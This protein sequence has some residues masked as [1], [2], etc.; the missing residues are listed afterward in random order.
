MLIQ[1]RNKNSRGLLTIIALC[2]ISKITGQAILTPSVDPLLYYKAT[3]EQCLRDEECASKCCYSKLCMETLKECASQR[4]ELLSK[5]LSQMEQR[6]LALLSLTQTDTPSILST[7]QEQIAYVNGT[8][9]LFDSSIVQNLIHEYSQLSSISGNT[10]ENQNILDIQELIQLDSKILL[11]SISRREMNSE[12]LLEHSVLQN[13]IQSEGSR[14]G[15]Y[16]NSQGNQIR[17]QQ[18]HNDEEVQKQP[19]QAPVQ[20]IVDSQTNM[21]KPDDETQING[22]TPS[23]VQSSELKNS[24]KDNENTHQETEA[25]LKESQNVQSPVVEESSS[26]TIESNREPYLTAL[27]ILLLLVLLGAGGL[28]VLALKGDSFQMR[29]KEKHW[30]YEQT[31]IVDDQYVRLL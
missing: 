11:P 5:I 12:H 31:D 29:L 3:N 27:V 24:D 8:I 9:G 1:R 13:D 20:S 19:K 30:L 4:Q 26:L 18:D 22:Q 7:N 21:D 15:A 28:I 10:V 16:L 2:C 23:Q 17:F 6:Q 14:E 25:E